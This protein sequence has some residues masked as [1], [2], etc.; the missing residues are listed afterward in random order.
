MA[1]VSILKH[2]FL[3]PWRVFLFL[4]T[5]R[6]GFVL[7]CWL[8]LGAACSSSVVTADLPVAADPAAALCS[9]W[10]CL[11]VSLPSLMWSRLLCPL[12]E[13]AAAKLQCYHS[14]EVKSNP[15][16]QGWVIM[17]A[18]SCEVHNTK[19]LFLFFSSGNLWT[20]PGACRALLP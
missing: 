6:L 12:S 18:L 9:A 3:W 5:G 15:A 7:R 10:C 2:S 14:S 13:H 4:L 16:Y 11:A 19:F 8:R 17:L 20:I 1:F